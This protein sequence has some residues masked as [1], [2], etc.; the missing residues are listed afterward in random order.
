MS[1]DLE[2]E[3]LKAN[4][5]PRP[6]PCSCYD[7]CSTHSLRAPTTSSMRQGGKER[8]RKI[9]TNL[10][11]LN[12]LAPAAP[13][14]KSPSTVDPAHIRHCTNSAVFPIKA[15]LPCASCSEGL[16]EASRSSSRSHPPSTSP[17]TFRLMFCTPEL[18]LRTQAILIKPPYAYPINRG[19]G[20]F[21]Q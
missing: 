19:K 20:D 2:R 14:S 17:H 11:R 5:E 1:R 10:N 12:L 15:E 18:A 21:Y 9:E 7:S 16:S 4:H 3:E 8:G 13:T 6:A